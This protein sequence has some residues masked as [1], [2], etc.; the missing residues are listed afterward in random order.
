MIETK[1]GIKIQERC[2]LIKS[3][4]LNT[5]GIYNFLASVRETSP[6]FQ[7]S[8]G[9]NAHAKV[10]CYGLFD[11]RGTIRTWTGAAPRDVVCNVVSRYTP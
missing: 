9:H 1:I 8:N 6:Q 2:V 4:L 3:F 5:S 7:R 10:F 11:I